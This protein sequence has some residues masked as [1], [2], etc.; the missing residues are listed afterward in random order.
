MVY[1]WTMSK[2]FF[3]KTQH[4]WKID[5]TSVEKVISVVKS[6]NAKLKEQEREREREMD[7]HNKERAEYM[8]L[9][10]TV[11]IWSRSARA[12]CLDCETRKSIL[13]VLYQ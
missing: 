7:E 9:T 3:V 8:Q 11:C 6:Y 13:H 1:S 12:F 10:W 5:V 2:H 4:A